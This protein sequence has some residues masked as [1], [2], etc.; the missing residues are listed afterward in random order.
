MEARP[1]RERGSGGGGHVTRLA[2]AQ[3]PMSPLASSSKQLFPTTDS[4]STTPGGLYSR[5]ST[6]WPVFAHEP[7][8]AK[9]PTGEFVMY[10]TTT[11]YLGFGADPYP[12]AH[13]ETSVPGGRAGYCD[14]CPGDGSSGHPNRWRVS[15]ILP[16]W[17]GLRDRHLA[18]QFG[19][20]L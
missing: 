9:A 17:S 14:N 10:F 16:P 2:R 18:Q 6:T 19:G 12:F 3:P 8:V 7:V 11:N 4:T 20:G 15:V 1:P 13:G 5:H